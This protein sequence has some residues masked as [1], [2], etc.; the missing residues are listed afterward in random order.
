MSRIRSIALPLLLLAIGGPP[1]G[2]D[3]RPQ[4][5]AAPAAHAA[6]VL[7]P[8]LEPISQSGIHCLRETG[9]HIRPGPGGCLE[10][11]YGTT[12][13]REEFEQRAGFT[14]GDFLKYDPSLNVH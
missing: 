6:A 3:A 1:A 11:A 9:S 8:P 7:P 10:G 2:A 4:P 14:T 5:E 12:V 13:D